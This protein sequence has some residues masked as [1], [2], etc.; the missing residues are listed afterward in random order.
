MSKRELNVGDNNYIYYI[1]EYS[2]DFETTNNLDD[3]S[4][5]LSKKSSFYITNQNHSNHIEIKS[6]SLKNYFNKRAIRTK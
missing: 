5:I 3:Y 1:K 4:Q 2:S 6:Q